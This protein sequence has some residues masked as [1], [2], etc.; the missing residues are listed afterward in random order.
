M[1]WDTPKGSPAMSYHPR[2]LSWI[3]VLVGALAIFLIYASFVLVSSPI[4]ATFHGYFYGIG[5]S[6]KLESS[7]TTVNEGS[8]LNNS[9][10]LADNKPSFD[11]QSSTVSTGT[12]DSAIGQTDTRSDSQKDLSESNSAKFPTSDDLSKTSDVSVSN[13]PEPVTSFWDSVD[14]ANSSLP[15]QENSQIDLTQSATM[16]VEGTDSS[17][18]TGS[19]RTAEPTSAVLIDQPH[20]V[21][22]TSNE[23]SM[24]SD[25]STSTTVPSSVENPNNTSQAG[26]VNSGYCCTLFTWH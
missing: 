5:S 8:I 2:P 3:V 18:V 11:P 1:T 16:P 7:V 24:A 9:S 6:E 15:A 10:D 13:S 17:N 12:S 25:N 14:V 19:I 20:P 21:I 26:S 23:T 4:G 22:T